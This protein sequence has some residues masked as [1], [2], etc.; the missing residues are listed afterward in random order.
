M[1]RRTFLQRSGLAFPGAAAVLAADRVEPT[2][3]SVLITS[4]HTRLA[5]ILAAGLGKQYRPVLT[6]AQEI[7]TEHEW[8][9]GDPLDETTTAD[10]VRGI[11]AIV[12]LAEPPASASTAAQVDV[13]TR[14]TYN[15]LQAAAAAGVTR[16]I[17]IS[18][19]DVM[20]GHGERFAVTEDWRPE[21]TT[22]AGAMSHWLGECTCRE[23]A[24]QGSISIVA[25]RFGRLVGEEEAGGKPADRPWLAESD[26]VQAVRLS[27]DYLRKRTSPADRWT[28]FHIL[29]AG[30]P[31]FP[32]SKAERL[33]GYRPEFRS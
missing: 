25:L 29:A 11:G 6:A 9:R 19:L 16:A 4:A 17:Y 5:P 23:F 22:A 27:L 12:H 14:A 8:R 15:L 10:L 24:R 2:A 13:R 30:C 26:A 31:R 32:I 20:Q 7:R 1:K 3:E 18:S 28:V 33:L 21:P